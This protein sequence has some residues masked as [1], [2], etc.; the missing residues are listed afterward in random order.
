MFVGS[1]AAG[2]L[3]KFLTSNVGGKD[4]VDWTTFWYIPAIGV[5]L[6]L[7]IFLVM[8]RSRETDSRQEQ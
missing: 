5:L 8:F 2:Y 7:A 3:A 4:V 1:I 6:S